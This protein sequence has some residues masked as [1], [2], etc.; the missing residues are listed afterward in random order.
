MNTKTTRRYHERMRRVL[1]HI[2]RHPD[3]DLSL[4]RLS[5]LAAFS[6]HH[7]HRQ[8][9]AYLGLP[10]H[11][12]V[13]LSRLERASHRLAYRAG[14]TVTTVALDA[15]YGAPDAFAR[16][17]RARLGQA[18]AAFRAAPDWASWHGALA[19]LTLARRNVMTVP[20]PADVGV[21]DRPAV[22]VVVL[23]H[24]GDPARLGE[25]IRRFIAFRKANHLPPARHDTYN[26]F[27][28]DPEAVAPADH[29]LG[30]AV[31]TD[32]LPTDEERAAGFYRD[33]VPAGRA[34][35]L[36][37]AGGDA[38]LAAAALVLYRDWL[39]PSGEAPAD[40]PLYGRRLSFFP[41][42]PES[43]AIMELYLPLR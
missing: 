27:H 4:D 28:T 13:Q 35:M 21:V 20:T 19:P 29:R 6:P 7:F 37:V 23:E 15:G 31:A 24:R 8:F 5:A 34:A 3:A 39:P 14:E 10:L 11:R 18:P 2:E 26:L 9:T 32:H 38:A 16:A 30:L 17:F 36:R 42:E 43:E 12:Y 33:V 40:A 41:D 1:D 25:T 22:P